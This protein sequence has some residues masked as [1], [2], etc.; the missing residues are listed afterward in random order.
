SFARKYSHKDYRILIIIDDPYGIDFHADKRLGRFITRC[1][2][3][4]ISIILGMQYLMTFPPV[5]RDNLSHYIICGANIGTI[6]LISKLCKTKEQIDSLETMIADIYPGLAV[7]LKSTG[8]LDISFLETPRC[9]N[10]I[11]KL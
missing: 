7:V 1:R 11:I 3:E 10:F 8:S 6:D 2:Q 5:L 9:K 4:N